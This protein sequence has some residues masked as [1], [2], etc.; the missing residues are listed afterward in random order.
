MKSSWLPRSP[1][2][3]G[4]PLLR[5]LGISKSAP[6]AAGAGITKLV[7]RGP[8]AWRQ[9]PDQNGERKNRATARCARG[10]PISKRN[11]RGGISR[12]DK[13][14]PGRCRPKCRDVPGGREKESRVRK[15]GARRGARKVCSQTRGRGGRSLASDGCPVAP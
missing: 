5:A 12:H 1:V 6:T 9:N 4:C 13:R 2:R 11:R 3:G 14:F 8:V 10:F 7:C 15:R